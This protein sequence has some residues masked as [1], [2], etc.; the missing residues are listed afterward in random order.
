MNQRPAFKHFDIIMAC[1]A[2]ILIISNIASSA[3]IVDLRYSLFG[4]R[5][6]FDGGT[7]IFPLSYILGDILTEVYG[8][9]AS[10]KAIWTGFALSALSAAVFFVLGLLP[11]E[12]L[13]EE[14][15]GSG[16]YAAILGGMSSGGIV[17]ASLAGFF[18]GE[19]SN[20][21]VLSRLKVLME[22]RLLFVR[23]ITST[24]AGE[25]LDTIV[26]VGAATAA[27]V[28]PPELFLELTVTNYILKCGIEILLTPATYLLCSSLKKSEGIDTFDRGIIY[29]PFGF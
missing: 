24:L 29:S 13:W 11:G 1:F 4:I 18:A 21:V 6:A 23:T 20:A 28:F 19:F 3:K 14:S 16:Q 26:F 8:F 10:R 5:L 2:V 15:A 7:L 27:G 25:F 9:R 12:A 17:F 22:G